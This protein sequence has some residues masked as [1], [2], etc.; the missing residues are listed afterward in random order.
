MSLLS[1]LQSFFHKRQERQQEEIVISVMPF[2][3]EAKSQL[4]SPP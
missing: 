4:A 2:V 3:N 1:R